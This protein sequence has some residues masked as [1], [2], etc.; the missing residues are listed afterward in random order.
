MAAEHL[1]RA[2][3]DLSDMTDC[4]EPADM[5]ETYAASAARLDEWWDGGRIGP[6]PAG[7]LR[8]IE[9]PA[10]GP[11]ARA[12]ATLPYVHLHD[13]DGRS[14]RLRRKDDF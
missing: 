9:P 3:A 12:I 8:R 7:R 11:L 5:F 1:D 13:P 2:A 14:G 6:R 10:L 4:L